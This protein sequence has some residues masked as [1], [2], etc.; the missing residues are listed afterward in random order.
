MGESPQYTL[1][2][3]ARCKAKVLLDLDYYTE[4]PV[5]DSN[6]NLFFT[7]L[8]GGRI[9]QFKNNELGVWAEAK[10][11]NGQAILATGDHLVCDSGS[12]W[13]GRY[14]NGGLLIEKMAWETGDDNVL[15]C[16][17]DIAVDHDG[18]YYTN[19]IRHSGAV[20]YIGTHGGKS[21]VAESLDYPNGIALT[22]D[23][24]CMFIA[25]SYTN[26]ILQVELDTPGIKKGEVEEF[27]ILPFHPQNRITGN[28]PDGIAIDSDGR[29]WV[30]HYGMQAVH[31]LSGSGELLASYDSG[32]PLTSNLCFDGKDILITGGF[33]EPGPGRVS[34]LTVFEQPY[35]A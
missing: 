7:D 5:M 4:G 25:E 20:Y 11:P 28:L 23:G 33:N 31:V 18:F 12:A 9:W 24:K 6:G 13:V 34:R 2:D 30:A 14:D 16:P 26:R 21:V 32:I 22:A 19:S 35:D 17:N 27:A 3:P 29:L 10:Q 8:V 1:R 15:H